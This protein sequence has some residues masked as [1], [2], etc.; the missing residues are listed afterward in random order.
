MKNFKGV[1]KK[2]EV[3]WNVQTYYMVKTDDFPRPMGIK[4]DKS[5]ELW[6]VANLSEY[7]TICELH[8]LS[9]WVEIEEFDS[10]NDNIISS[11]IIIDKR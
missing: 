10:T 1:L 5:F 3:K 9:Y 7:V 2:E 8:S 4:T 6:D 11:I